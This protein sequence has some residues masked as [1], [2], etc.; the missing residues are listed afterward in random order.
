MKLRLLVVAFVV[1][2]FSVI[3]ST[4]SAQTVCTSNCTIHTSQTFSL[5]ADYYGNDIE[6][7]GFRLYQDGVVVATAPSSALA[8]GV[9]TF[10]RPAITTAGSHTFMVAAFNGGGETRSS[11]IGLTVIAPQQQPPGQPSGLRITV[12]RE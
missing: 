8:D 2:V 5:A 4:A 6:D 11:S 10:V 9:I 7:G 3:G 12:T 1:A